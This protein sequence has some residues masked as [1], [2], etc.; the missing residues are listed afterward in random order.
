MVENQAKMISMTA[1]AKKA[2]KASQLD[3]ISL[4][5]ELMGID[6]RFKKSVDSLV[7]MYDEFLVDKVPQPQFLP[8]MVNVRFDTKQNGNDSRGIDDIQCRPF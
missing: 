8:V 1:K 5:Q 3:S 6:D 7:K 2:N 4:Q